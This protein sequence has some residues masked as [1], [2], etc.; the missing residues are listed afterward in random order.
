MI[1][2]ISQLTLYTP[3]KKLSVTFHPQGNLQIAYHLR[4]VGL[5]KKHRESM[6]LKAIIHQNPE[7][8]PTFRLGFP[9]HFLASLAV[10]FWW[11]TGRL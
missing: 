6:I 3:E 1:L 4:V 7:Q 11:V 8:K 9:S 2:V 10:R 5:L